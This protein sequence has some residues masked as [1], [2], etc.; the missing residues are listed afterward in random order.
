MVRV[1]GR[2]LPGTALDVGQREL[3]EISERY[4]NGLSSMMASR[5]PAGAPRLR[6]PFADATAQLVPLQEQL[7]RQS[8]TTLYLLLGAVAFV[9][10]IACANIANLQLARA[11]TRQRDSAVRAA[12]GAS[13]RR[14]AAELVVENLL[15]AIAGGLLGVLLAW[16]GTQALQAWLADYLPRIN[17]VGV[18][19]PVLG[20]AVALALVA[21][22]GFGLAPAWRVR[23]IDL[24]DT[25]KEGGHQSSP[26]GARWRQGLVALEVA[27]ALVLAINTGLL[28][29]S[30]HH[31]TSA[32]L[33]Y[34]TS[35]VLT[36]NLA[37]P[38]RYGT[39]Q[40]QSDF[41]ARWLAA[42]Q[43][44]PGVKTAALTDIPPLAPYAQM[45]LSA[46]Q[47]PGANATSAAPPPSMSV[48]SATPDY[49]RAT[50]IALR[51]GRFFTEADAADTTAVAV[52]NEEFVRQFHPNGLTL[53]E[54]INLPAGGVAH[55][56]VPTGKI[57]GVVANIRARGFES[58]AQPM[59]FFPLAQQ[60]RARLSAVLQFEGDPST[61]ARAVTTATHKIDADLALDQPQTLE[62]QLARQ[63]APRRVTLILTGAFA[64]TA[65]LL[66]ALGIFG[67]M[68][69]TVTQRTREIGVRMALGADAATILRWLLRYAGLAI[70][71]GL[72]AGV[73]ITFVTLRLIRS[74]L[75][76][77][78]SLDPL[79]VGVGV[80]TLAL[81]GLLACLVP[82]F[83]AT[84]V[85]PL[86]ALR[87]E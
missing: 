8:R 60:P 16:W 12:L 78:T 34:R 54:S 48:A 80:G 15:L 84:R 43:S 38:R 49:F 77:I 29:Q 13:P 58:S 64:A 83:R 68:S 75:T 46:G 14:L 57:I 72:V 81:V 31:L 82:A 42:L 53:G 61:L 6:L 50:G 59:A 28:V 69:Y 9:L 36:A 63:T 52:V 55:G 41:A 56:N 44:L 85:N 21:G 74:L 10:L 37:L 66:A 76:G 40:Q 71:V 25:L 23:R 32:E 35:D 3:N 11:A 79:V 86:E 39:P 67:V 17:P 24:L 47:R 51:Q 87:S 45:V 65:V 26:T 5:A 73:A 33:G 70:G 62:Q 1:F 20:F 7:A 2:L 19:A 18:N 30:I 22:I 27:L 4:W